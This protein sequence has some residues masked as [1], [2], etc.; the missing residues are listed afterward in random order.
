MAQGRGHGRRDLQIVWDAAI[1]KVPEIIELLRR[2]LADF[3]A[4]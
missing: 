4:D 3:G 2:L 1:N